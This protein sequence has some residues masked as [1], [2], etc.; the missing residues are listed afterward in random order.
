VSDAPVN[1]YAPPPP[2][3]SP[4]PKEE[5]WPS[6]TRVLLPVY[7]VALLR[8]L[9]NRLWFSWSFVLMRE[10][11]TMEWWATAF[12]Y[13]S[14][15]GGVAGTLIG[16]FTGGSRAARPLVLASLGLLMAGILGTLAVTSHAPAVAIQV[17]TALGPAVIWLVLTGYALRAVTV[18]GVYLSM[19]LLFAASA[20]AG[21]GASASRL[22]IEQPV[23][24]I[25]TA[26]GCG[27]L[28]LV[29][30]FWLLAP[31]SRVVEMET[32]R[33]HQ[34]R[35]GQVVLVV[36]LLGAFG[37]LYWNWSMLSIPLRAAEGVTELQEQ[38]AE[39]PRVGWLLVPIIAYLAR[40]RPAYLVVAGIGT[41]AAGVFVG[42]LGRMAWPALASRVLFNL[43]YHVL[44][45]VPSMVLV[46]RVV[47]LPRIVFWIG[48][49][50]ITSQVIRIGSFYLIQLVVGEV[51][52]T[53]L[54]GTMIA[55]LMLGIGVT[56]AI[57]VR[58]LGP[59]E[60]RAPEL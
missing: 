54:V 46:R 21:A 6:R 44:Y 33:D 45:E 36:L 28:A 9:A 43:G 14:L 23:I 17:A 56:L 11:F 31:G 2:T 12:S 19:T 25:S 49:Q 24:G 10:R 18:R 59:L 15:G 32:E 13:T 22:V 38:L 51:K 30:A 4:P 42:A 8:G 34:P 52:A 5:G 41:T 53:A 35:L 3:S 55:G 50:Y 48:M 7:L 27:G 60:E 37:G 16:S 47:P 29:A 39:L 58:R 1:P 40:W 57:A 20:L 26:A